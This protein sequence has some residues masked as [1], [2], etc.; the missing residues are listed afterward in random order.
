MEVFDL[1]EANQYG[2][3]RQGETIDALAHFVENARDTLE[4]QPKC[5][6]GLFLDLKKAFDTVD[7]NLFLRK[8]ADIGLRGPMLEIMKSYLSDRKQFLTY[9]AARTSPI[10]VTFGVPQGSVLG[11]LFSSYTS[12][13]SDNNATAAQ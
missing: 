12:L 6:I 4:N 1:L 7:H 13:T 11:P 2:F 10:I 8:N 3:R 9:D 5:S